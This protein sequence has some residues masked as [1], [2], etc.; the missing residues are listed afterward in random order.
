[1]EAENMPGD[2]G[3]V[4]NRRRLRWGF[5]VAGIMGPAAISLT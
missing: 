4:I 5:G 1:M 2:A 3:D